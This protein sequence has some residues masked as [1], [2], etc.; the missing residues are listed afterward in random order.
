MMSTDPDFEVFLHEEASRLGLSRAEKAAFIPVMQ[1]R[2]I[3][4]VAKDLDVRPEAIRQRLSLVYKKFEIDGT[5]PVKSS[6]L[7]RLLQ[8]RYR[9]WQVSQGIHPGNAGFPLAHQSVESPDWGD[10]PD[11]PKFYGRT[12]E[13]ETLEQWI[14]GDKC[15]LV[16]LSG[17]TGIGKTALA[18]TVA[19]K[20]AKQRK[21]DRILW[22]S[23]S[24]SK[25]KSLDGL[26]DE[27]L[28]SLPLA[29][30]PKSDTDGK[31]G[32]LLEILNQV[33]CLIILDNIE[34]IIK[35]GSRLA[36]YIEGYED[37]FGDV[38]R[39]VVSEQ[40]KSCVFLISQYPPREI[41]NLD[42]K[43]KSVRS[44]QLNK[45]QFEEFQ[46]FSSK[47]ATS[48]RGSHLK[49]LWDY[50]EGNPLLLNAALQSIADLFEGNL[51][52]FLKFCKQTA[53]L[54]SFGLNF[55]DFLSHQF[56][57][58]SESEQ[59]LIR[60]FSE[61]QHPVSIAEITQ[62]SNTLISELKSPTELIETLTSLK[63]RSWLEITSDSSGIRYSC[64]S[65]LKKYIE[66]YQS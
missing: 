23:I 32:Q 66:K 13:L 48:D 41:K 33:R 30:Q 17:L 62:A 54:S 43:T 56:E 50:C 34:E 2:E 22:R 65:L 27:L 4:D 14:V 11:V 31:I 49:T 38:L 28:A 10:A 5:G 18:K 58:M 7:Q 47:F 40:D 63:Q 39:Q 37:R 19:E 51:A 20:I 52:E 61:Q 44:Q 59:N 42:S 6:K 24:L 53:I 15:R 46:A 3:Q 12:A 25:F 64:S 29:S 9:E 16:A 21:F 45:L 26:L 60:Y 55:P 8:L 36:G 1:N 35:P 57:K